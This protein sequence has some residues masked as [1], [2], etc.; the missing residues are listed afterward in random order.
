MPD[1]TVTVSDAARQ[2]L[3]LVVA[4]Y[5]AEN[6]S[7]LDLSRWLALHFRELAVQRE[8]GTRVEQLK[9]QAEDD[10]SAAINAEKARLLQSVD[11]DPSGVDGSQS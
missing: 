8:F 6:G 5:N 7:S 4:D 11:P 9:R 10:L 3:D 1:V 2:R